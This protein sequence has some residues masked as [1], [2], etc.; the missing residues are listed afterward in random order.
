MLKVRYY[1]LFTVGNGFQTRVGC[2]K[3]DVCVDELIL[4][5]KRV[6]G[7][8]FFKQG[9]YFGFCFYREYERAGGI[10]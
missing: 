8:V 7:C 6:E 3:V 9:R 1:L 2:G 5:S 10:V 4:S